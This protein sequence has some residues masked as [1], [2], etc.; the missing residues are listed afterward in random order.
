MAHRIYRGGGAGQFP[1]F[2]SAGN[3]MLA[4]GFSGGVKTTRSV[5]A[6]ASPAWTNLSGT[7]STATNIP[8]NSF[9][10]INAALTVAAGGWRVDRHRFAGDVEVAGFEQC[11]DHKAAAGFPL[12]PAAMAAMHDH[13][14]GIHPVTHGAAVATAFHHLTT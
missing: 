11:V 14:R 9:V 1:A 2:A 4:L 3:K 7:I 13:G 8:A 10:R 6:V 12:A 5:Q